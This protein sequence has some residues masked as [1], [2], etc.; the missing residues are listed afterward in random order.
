MHTNGNSCCATWSVR[1]TIVTLS[2]YHLLV[3]PGKN[4]FFHTN[5]WPLKYADSIY[6]FLIILFALH[7]SNLKELGFSVKGLKRSLFIGSASG[8]VLVFSLFLLD[9]CIDSTGMANHDLFKNQPNLTISS[10]KNS[11]IEY[12]GLVLVIP[13]IEQI[14]FTGIIYQSIHKKTSPI[15]AIYASGIIYSLAGYKLSLGS[16][17]LGFTTSFLFKTTKTI[18]ASIIFHV[19]CAVG[20][21]MIK[22]I[23][24]RLNTFLG[25]LF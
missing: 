8:G 14:F 19:S 24:P 11:I 12:A 22:T 21:I 20:E 15:L 18:Y 1:A 13:L 6:F 23:Y 5:P 7:R 17:G 2:V 9:L 16:F 25:F 10:E 3:L 4:I